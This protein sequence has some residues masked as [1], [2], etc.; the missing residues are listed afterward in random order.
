VCLGLFGGV[1]AGDDDIG[2]EI[3]FVDR[4]TTL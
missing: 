3:D 4:I 2:N 1:F